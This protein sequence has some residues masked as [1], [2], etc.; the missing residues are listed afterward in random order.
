MFLSKVLLTSIL[1]S[2]TAVDASPLSRSTGKATLS[3]AA[4]F[5]PSG[6]LNVVERDRAHVESFKNADYLGKRST[7]AIGVT[8]A[9]MW[10]T[11]QIGIGSPSTEC[12]WIFGCIMHGLNHC[13][14]A[15]T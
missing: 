12:M 5:N 15:C 3:I 10:Y 2:L 1:V 6:T 11:A 8:N 7:T 13:R 9:V 14:H 4:R